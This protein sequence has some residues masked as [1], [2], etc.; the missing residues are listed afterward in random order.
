MN[1]AVM[2]TLDNLDSTKYM[3][4]IMSLENMLA[5]IGSLERTEQECRLNMLHRVLRFCILSFENKEFL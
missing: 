1:M 3:Y 2:P 5:R 4:E